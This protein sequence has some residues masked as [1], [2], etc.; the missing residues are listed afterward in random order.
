[1]NILDSILQRAKAGEKMLVRLIDPDKFDASTICDGFDFYFV[2]GSTAT[3]CASVVRAIHAVCSTPVILFP[4]SPSQFTP[5]A[6]ALL[7]LTLM[8]SRDPRFLIDGHIQSADAIATSG[9]ESIP[10]GYIL[11]EGG[12]ESTTQRLT[13]AQPAS[14]QNADESVRLAR[15]AQLL[16]KRL[17]YLEAGSGAN[18]PVPQHIIRAVR[19]AIDLPLIV[20][21]GICEP[22]Q[23]SDAF[24]AGA[25]LVVIGNHFESHPEQ[26]PLFLARRNGN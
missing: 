1:M 20:G 16:G 10:M 12:R 9:I 4:G 6:D 8:N 26:I 22:E 11:V 17:I 13:G 7:F 21:G 19:E 2:G 23:M 15:T 3:D 18:Q 25:D 5:E 14:A 24:V